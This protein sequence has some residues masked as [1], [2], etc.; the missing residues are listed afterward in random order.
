MG[1]QTTQEE[2]RL[3]GNAYIYKTR[4]DGTRYRWYTATAADQL[5][6][7]IDQE[8][9][10]EGEGQPKKAQVKRVTPTPNHSYSAPRLRARG[11]VEGEVEVAVKLPG[12]LLHE[13]EELAAKRGAT[14]SELIRVWVRGARREPLVYGLKAKMG[15]GKYKGEPV[16]AVIR[17]DPSYIVWALTK[18]DHFCIDEEATELLMKFDIEFGVNKG[19]PDKIVKHEEP[20]GLYGQQ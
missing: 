10:A 2:R 3:N 1:K 16:E 19:L 17:A 12:E 18:T 13:V 7:K 9:P 14:V 5:A 8:L 4:K 20:E 6:L 15:F 11:E